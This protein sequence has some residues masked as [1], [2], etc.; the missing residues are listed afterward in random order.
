MMKIAQKKYTYKSKVSTLRLLE[1]N[2]FNY[3]KTEKLTGVSRSTIKKWKAQ[4]GEEVFTGASPTEQALKEVDVQM[5]I[6]DEL[7][8]RKYY[9]LRNQIID[10]LQELIPSETKL[11]PLINALK[12]I[13]CELT[14]F[15]EMTKKEVES[16]RG[17]VFQTILDNIEKMEMEKRN[18]NADQN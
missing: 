5:K 1:K 9:T 16:K 7:I 18:S 2:D 10:R 17:T 8:I 3:L 12:G 13:S 6:N 14:V 4:Y 15:D 11:E